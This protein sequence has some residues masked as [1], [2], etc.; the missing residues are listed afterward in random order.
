VRPALTLGD[1]EQGFKILYY[2]IDNFNA[3]YFSCLIEFMPPL[4]V[5][6]NIR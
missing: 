6:E 3:A 4:F 5:Y 2:Y 1:A